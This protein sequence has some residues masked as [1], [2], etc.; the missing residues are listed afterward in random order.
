M[1][2]SA[3]HTRSGRESFL[4]VAITGDK[5]VKAP[6]WAVAELGLTGQ[7]AQSTERTGRDGRTINTANIGK[8]PAP[9]PPAPAPAFPPHNPETGELVERDGVPIPARVPAEVWQAAQRPVP[10]E[11]AYTRFEDAMREAG[12]S[13]RAQELHRLLSRLLE[14]ERD[15]AALL[16]T[17]Y[18]QGIGLHR[19]AREAFDLLEHWLVTHQQDERVITVEAGA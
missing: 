12:E 17:P 9:P 14:F 7:I 11:T 15:G 8:R 1:T 13:P 10:Q 6:T 19:A 2:D 5:C 16:A 3:A 4:R 18:A